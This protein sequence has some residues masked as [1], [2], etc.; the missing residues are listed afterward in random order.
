M[1][2]TYDIVLFSLFSGLGEHVR[3]LDYIIPMSSSPLLVCLPCPMLGP[4][5]SW[6][7]GVW[8][9]GLGGGCL[10]LDAVFSFSSHAAAK[11]SSPVPEMQVPVKTS[12]GL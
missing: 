6:P 4:L 3:V 8:D 9:T 10:A 7:C 2:F 1:G 11:V 12:G 5:L